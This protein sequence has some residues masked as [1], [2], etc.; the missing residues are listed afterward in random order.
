MLTGL[1]PFGQLSASEIVFKVLEGGRPLRP[2]DALEL[3]LT[4]R[5]WNLLEDCW[6]M[7][8]ALR[9][10]VKDVLGRLKAAALVCGPLPPVKVIPNRYEDPTSD[11]TKFGRP[12]PPLTK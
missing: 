1:S 9:P 3:G 11:F 10:S 7:E 12:F 5:V 2:A 6:R 4:D 8:H